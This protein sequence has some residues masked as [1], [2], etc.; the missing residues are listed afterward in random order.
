MPEDI[1]PKFSEALEA[2]PAIDSQS[3]NVNIHAM[4]KVLYPVRLDIPYDKVDATHNLVGIIEPTDEYCAV[5]GADFVDPT[6]KYAYPDDTALPAGSDSIT[7]ARA[8]A[9]WKVAIDDHMSWDMEDPQIHHRE[10]QR[11]VDLQEKG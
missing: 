10:G 8:K 11:D 6:R 2:F 3:R 9:D 1:L 5:Y 7:Q 4:R